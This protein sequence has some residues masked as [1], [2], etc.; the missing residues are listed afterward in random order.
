MLPARRVSVA[1]RAGVAPM[2]V[3]TSTADA[4][5][6]PTAAAAAAAAAATAAAVL[7]SMD[8][9][10]PSIRRISVTATRSSTAASVDTCARASSWARFCA[11]REK[12]D[13]P[14]DSAASSRRPARSVAT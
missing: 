12:S 5:C 4:I 11:I 6:T 1:L 9:S 10:S 3:A 7:A 8:V 2:S 14:R 13:A